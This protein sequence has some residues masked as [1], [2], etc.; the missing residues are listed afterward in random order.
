[1]KDFRDIGRSQM[2]GHGGQMN[3]ILDTIITTAGNVA[4]NVW[5][6]RTTYTPPLYSG[7]GTVQPY[8][9]TGTVG[10]LG[11][12]TNTLMIIGAGLVLLLALKKR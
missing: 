9:Y 12:S 7:G 4:S 3:G 6:N 10:G 1:M 11:I 2:T 5:G 8:P